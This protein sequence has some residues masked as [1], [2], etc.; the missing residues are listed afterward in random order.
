[1]YFIFNFIPV[2]PFEILHIGPLN[3]IKGVFWVLAVF[4]SHPAADVRV[5]YRIKSSPFGHF[6]YFF[7]AVSQNLVPINTNVTTEL[8]MFIKQKN[9]L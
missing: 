2:D 6:L 8:F 5:T 4:C 1:M 7:H 9:I 3:Y